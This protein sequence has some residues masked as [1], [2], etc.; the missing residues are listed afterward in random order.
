MLGIVIASQASRPDIIADGGAR[1]FAVAGDGGRMLV[2]SR[3]SARFERD[4][5]LRRAGYEMGEEETWPRRGEGDALAGLRCDDV[6]CVWQARGYEISFVTDRG[7]LMDDCRSASIVVSAV[8]VPGRRCPSARVLIDRYD[9]WRNGTHAIW[10]EKDGVRVESVNGARGMRPWVVRPD[11][12]RPA[13]RR[14]TPT[15][16]EISE[17]ESEDAA[18]AGDPE[19]GVQ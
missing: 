5:W 10:L 14:P 9:L 6:G 11:R 3:A 1:L 7:A 19:T 8:P 16:Q 12:R 13:V 15:D 17:T 18:P 2:S 4:I